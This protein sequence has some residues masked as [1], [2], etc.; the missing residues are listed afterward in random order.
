MHYQKACFAGVAGEIWRWAAGRKA[1]LMHKQE[2]FFGIFSLVLLVLFVCGMTGMDYMNRDN[3]YARNI[4]GFSLFA[5]PLL[6]LILSMKS[7]QTWMG[8][9]GL[10]VSVPLCLFSI[11]A[12]AWV[13]YYSR[14]SHASHLHHSQSSQQPNN[15]LHP[16][17]AAF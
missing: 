14:L 12:L 5:L 2:F 11:G 8:I 4:I 17:P 16:S 6:S 9:V 13:I 7:H 3:G 10:F 1:V 15:S